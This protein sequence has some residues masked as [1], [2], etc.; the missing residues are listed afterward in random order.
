MYERQ[1]GA[2]YG[3]DSS[4][5]EKDAAGPQQTSDVDNERPDKHERR[6]VGAVEPRTLVVTDTDMTLQ[7]RHPQ[8]KHAAGKRDQPGA[9]EDASYSQ[10]RLGGN[11]SGNRYSRG[12]RDLRRGWRRRWGTGYDSSRGHV[13][14]SSGQ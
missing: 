1:E 7:I 5:E 10:Q 14:F 11:V 8:R 12:T 6:I 13:I 9:D 3:E 2:G 4:R